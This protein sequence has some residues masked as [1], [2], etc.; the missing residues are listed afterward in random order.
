MGELDLL[1]PV[2]EHY[3]NATIHF[4][5]VRLKPGK[6]TTF[7]TIPNGTKSKLVFALPGNPV[8]ALVTCYLFV[9]PCLKGLSGIGNAEHDSI[10]VKLMHDIKLDPRPEFY[11]VVLKLVDGVWEATGTGIQISSRISSMITANGLLKLPIS[12]NE[13]PV[14]KAGSVLPAYFLQ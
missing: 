2:L 12:T 7:A 4:G 8:S 3:L 13:Q 1:K 14:L 9:V 5:R 10:A 6:P 11:R